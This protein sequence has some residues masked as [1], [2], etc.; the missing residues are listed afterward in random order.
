MGCNRC[1]YLNINEAQ[2]N[3]MEKQCGCLLWHYCKKYN[4][5]LFHFPFKEP[6]ITPCQECIDEK[7][8]KTRC[9]SVSLS[10]KRGDSK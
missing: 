2:Q 10:N 4:K 1:E 9:S 7:I 5:R 6:Y 8:K 3:K